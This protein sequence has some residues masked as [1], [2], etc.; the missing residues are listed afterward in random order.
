MLTRSL[1]WLARAL[2]ASA[3]LGGFNRSDAHLVYHQLAL[4]HAEWRDL[5][6]A[7]LALHER[8]RALRHRAFGTP[9]ADADRIN[10]VLV[11]MLFEDLRA[12]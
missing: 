10:A 12:E 6:A 8:A 7:V 9:D 1:A 3:D 4:T 2:R 11:L 5:G